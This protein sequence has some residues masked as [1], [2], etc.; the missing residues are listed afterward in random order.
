MSLTT[1]AFTIRPGIAADC[2]PVHRL[3]KEL[4]IFEK[5]PAAVKTSPE[6]FRTSVFDKK[7]G[8]EF[9]VAEQG[10][11]IVGTA[12]YYPAYSTWRGDYIYLEDL[13]VTQEK[14]S[15]GIGKALMMELLKIADQKNAHRIQW[16]VLDWNEDAIRFYRRMGVDISSQW[17]DVYHF[18]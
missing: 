11:M 1:E 10:G 7:T 17:L 8:V 16:Q 12:I 6:D 5:E 2:E 14:R 3:I 18:I 4:A 13:I 15:Q 9:I